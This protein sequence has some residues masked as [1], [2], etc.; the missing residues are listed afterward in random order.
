MNDPRLSQFPLGCAV[1]LGELDSDPYAVY[2]RLRP[3]EPLSWL[4]ATGMYYALTHDLVHRLLLD[5]VNFVVGWETSTVYDTFGTHMMSCEGRQARRQKRPHRMAFLPATIRQTLEPDIRDTATQLV[6]TFR[7]HGEVDIRPAFAARLPILVMLNLFGLP[8]ADE[9]LF[10][11]WYDDF[12]A[13]LANEHFDPAIRARGQAAVAAFH[14]HLQPVI[15]T[16]RNN[17]PDGSLLSCLTHDDRDDR[18][19]DEEIRHNA[20]IVMFGGISTVEALILNTLWLL[21]HHPDWLER[22]RT[23]RSCLPAV[24][25]ESIRLIGPVQSA[26]RQVTRDI[27]IDGV[28]LKQGDIINLILSAAN[29]DPAVFEAPDEFR[30]GRPN[31]ARHLGFAAG[32]HLCLGMHLAR[33]EA[34]IALNTLF[35]KLPGLKPDISRSTAPSGA[36]FRQP[37][38]LI[39][40]W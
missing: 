17:P 10:R 12:E 35:D 27:G 40:S 2:A 25:E 22:V 36:V 4:P 15:E 37:G 34:Q 20:L 39:A 11:S 16:A 14:A 19:T 38:C 26:T 32:P 18:L 31:I 7:H 5:D 29:H 1:S 24:L 23:D 13:A 28:K 8:A 21:A 9:A 30:P 33:A 6:N 3:T